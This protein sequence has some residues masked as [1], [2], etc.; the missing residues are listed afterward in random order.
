MRLILHIFKKDFRHHWPAL[1]VSFA[2]LAVFV[3]D[4]PRHWTVHPPDLRFVSSL[5]Q[6]LPLF[7]SLAWV[8]LL[9]RIVQD[10]SL[11][12]D[13]QFWLTRPYKWHRSEERRV[14]K[15]CRSRW[16]PYH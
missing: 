9:I 4:Q 1:L 11:V 3:W 15:E 8:F 12:G 6:Y 5:L 7:L 2:I 16:S 13:R 14:G 10:E